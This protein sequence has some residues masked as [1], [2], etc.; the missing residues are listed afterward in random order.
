[1]TKKPVKTMTET[2]T[3]VNG[4]EYVVLKRQLTP[5][6]VELLRG[7][8]L[9][10]KCTPLGIIMTS[11]LLEY[12]R[13]TPPKQVEKELALP[14]STLDRLR[15]KFSITKPC[16]KLPMSFWRER[17][18]DL[19]SMTTKEFLAKYGLNE[20]MLSTA[21]K[22]RMIFRKER[23][24]YVID[25]IRRSLT[26]FLQRG[27]KTSDVVLLQVSALGKPYELDS[28]VREFPELDIQSVSRN[29]QGTFRAIAK[30]DNAVRLA[31]H[32]GL[33]RAIQ[34]DNYLPFAVVDGVIFVLPQLVS[35]RPK[36]SL[37]PSCWCARMTAERFVELKNSGSSL[38]QIARQFSPPQ[39]GSGYPSLGVMPLIAAGFS[40]S[41]KAQPFNPRNPLDAYYLSYLWSMTLGGRMVSFTSE[42]AAHLGQILTRFGISSR[43]FRTERNKK[44]K[45]SIPYFV[46]YTGLT[47]EIE[48]LAATFNVDLSLPPT[49]KLPPNFDIDFRGF[50]CGY[51]MI[52]GWI[53]L[54]KTNYGDRVLS[55]FIGSEAVMRWFLPFIE[56]NIGTLPKP[57]RPLNKVS[58]ES[59]CWIIRFWQN[60][61]LKIYDYLKGAHLP[62]DPGFMS[63]AREYVE[64]CR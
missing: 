62:L 64:K 58:P 43:V 57:I 10:S 44:S 12:L 23:G 8:P 36:T 55:G 49:K 25:K 30:G 9:F 14:R 1:M 2:V 61:T 3:D 59:G 51:F 40:S 50:F 41:V 31:E 24:T 4:V 7:K 18:D 37:V 5:V 38:E 63:R 6:G 48:S 28:M 45:K 42:D 13:R 17:A 46:S 22:Y 56:K 32:F 33:C 53:S 20:G 11:E 27:F 19:L 34:F 39:Y 26:T 60:D 16:V 15:T 29:V 35:W 21:T 52:H 47:D 54:S